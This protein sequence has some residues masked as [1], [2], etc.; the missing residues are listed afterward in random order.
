MTD[1]LG[2]TPPPPLLPSLADHFFPFLPHSLLTF[3]S[4]P[5][6]VFLRIL[7]KRKKK[8]CHKFSWDFYCPG[9]KKLYVKCAWLYIFHNDTEKYF[10]IHMNFFFFWFL[11]IRGACIWIFWNHFDRWRFFFFLWVFFF[12]T[13]LNFDRHYCSSDCRLFWRFSS[14]QK[15][16]KIFITL[17]IWFGG[18]RGTPFILI[19]SRV[20]GTFAKGGPWN[21]IT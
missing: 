14:R 2:I 12:L 19:P 9:K 20:S 7:V 15:K 5:V 17:K 3:F 10:W 18:L 8:F 16:K 4:H 6:C 13:G 1:P 21:K 11:W